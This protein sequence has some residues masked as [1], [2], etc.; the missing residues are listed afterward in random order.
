MCTVYATPDIEKVK[1]KLESMGVEKVAHKHT[2]NSN[3]FFR[4]NLK[5]NPAAGRVHIR[6]SKGVDAMQSHEVVTYRYVGD[7]EQVFGFISSDEIKDAPITNEEL[8]ALH[9]GGS[10]GPEVEEEAEEELEEEEDQQ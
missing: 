4:G 6:V 9:D 1:A 5:D 2:G 10:T 7:Q 3:L 8:D